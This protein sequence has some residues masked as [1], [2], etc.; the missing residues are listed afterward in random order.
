[1]I[2]ILVNPSQIVSVSTDKNNLKRGHEMNDLNILYDHSIVIEN[3]LIKDIVPN[4]SLGSINCDERIDIT[5]K[6]ILPGLVECHTHLVFAGSRANEVRMKVAGASYEDIANSGGGIV[7]T[8]NAV[9]NSSVEELLA[10]ARVRVKNFI[11][12]GVTSLEIKS[13]YG[14]NFE[15][16]IKILKVIQILK[17]EFQI[18]I[19]P[20]FL[21][22]HTFAPE[23]KSNRDEYLN[24]IM[25][26]MLPYIAENK[27]AD[28]CDGFCEKTAF[29]PSE[30]DVVFT[31][32]RQLRLKIKLHT[33]QFNAIG[34]LQIALKHNP[35][36]VDHLEVL[37]KEDVN[38]FSNSQIVAVLLPGVSHYLDYQFAPA[39]DII[40]NN[41]IVALATDFNPGSSPISNV[42]IIMS[43]A[44]IKMK[45]T[46]E[47][48][49][50]AYTI[51]SAKAL[52]I[53]QEKGSIEIGKKADFSI[54]NTNDY[55]NIIYSIGTNLCS[56]VIKNGKTIYEDGVHL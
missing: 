17:Q 26:E 44:A 13:G 14:L 42:S 32:A 56:R 46:F 19:I 6:V 39:R 34:G 36:S 47:E 5:D 20:T 55:A 45:M 49:I 29:T 52:D 24:S 12:Q 21:G 9:R 41:G 3:D 7:S 53:H 25:N 27:L 35:L 40:D 30:I 15:N 37:R 18:D 23:Y 54:F 50:T 16:E 33:E 22:A 48:I 43:L 11:S 1:M 31:K 28:S 4:H 2:K 51:N 8:M 38:L 10:L